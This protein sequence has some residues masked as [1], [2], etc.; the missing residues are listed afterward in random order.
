MY[1]DRAAGS[2]PQEVAPAGLLALISTLAVQGS[3]H[4]LTSPQGNMAVQI[5]PDSV[6]LVDAQSGDDVKGAIRSLSAKP[7]RTIVN[8][9]A[10]K[11]QTSGNE[12]LSAMGQTI[13]GGNVAGANAGFPATIVAHENVTARM[14]E[15]GAPATAWP[16]NT[17][18][19][20]HKDLFLNGEAAQVLHMPNAHSDADSIVFFRRSDVI[21]TG[22]IFSPDRY[23]SIDVANGG[24]INGEVAA[25]N[26][27]LDLTIPADKQEGGTMLIPAHGRVCDEADL[28]EYRDMVTILRDRLQDMVKKGMTLEQVVAAKPTR[29]YDPLYGSGD[30]FVSAAY[31]SLKK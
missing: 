1:P 6:M 30:A 8:T 29:D 5:G 15:A 7:I 2:V 25:L 13:T 4:M 18:V 24:T 26:R 12:A 27:L 16:G 23:P 31:R 19:G 3:V 20:D 22:E 9:S 14:T 17:Y 21:A 28:V 10:G 11:A